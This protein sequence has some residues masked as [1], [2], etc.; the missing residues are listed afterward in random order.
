[1]VTVSAST[2]SDL[3]ALGLSDVRLVPEGVD[4]P[5]DF[6]DV[7]KEAVP[8]LL[9]VGR[10]A[11]NK[12]PEDAVRAFRVVQD[13]L[14]QARLWIIGQG[15]L[16][17]RLRR[18]LPSGADLLGFLP[19]AE[20]YRRM[21]RAHCLLVP[22]VREGWG[23]VV[24][25]ANSVGTPAVGYDVPGIR[26]SIRGGVTGLL[27][28]AGDPAA[29][30][31]PMGPWR[32]ERPRRRAGTR[33]SPRPTSCWRSSRSSAYGKRCPSGPR[34]LLAFPPGTPTYTS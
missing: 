16:E 8:T 26:D 31:R 1:M 11:A 6:T 29:L 2:R 7:Q 23:L 3:L 32:A 30:P 13:S 25:E 9:Y 12:R 21:A 20:M 33:G 18:S 5:P 10:L 27:A 34:N 14:P 15:P 24:S 17:E 28:D 19:R 22:S 4:R